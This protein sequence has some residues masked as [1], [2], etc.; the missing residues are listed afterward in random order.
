ML[1]WRIAASN[2]HSARKHREQFTRDWDSMYAERSFAV[3]EFE[4]A[5]TITGGVHAK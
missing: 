3:R 4:F 5:Q 1:E 2:K